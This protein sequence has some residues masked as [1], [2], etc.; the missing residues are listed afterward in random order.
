VAAG[1]GVA[2][3]G[4][5]VA[6]VLAVPDG[7]TSLLEYGGVTLALLV[8][9]APASLWAAGLLSVA[10]VVAAGLVVAALTHRYRLR[11]KSHAGHATARIALGVLMAYSAWVLLIGVVLIFTFLS[12]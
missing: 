3:V 7:G 9:Y 6:F 1:A 2:S 10:P 4:I 12:G 5:T 8:F 11:S